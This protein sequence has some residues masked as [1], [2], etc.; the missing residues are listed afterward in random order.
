MKIRTCK[1]VRIRGVSATATAAMG[2]GFGWGDAMSRMFSAT[3]TSGTTKFTPSVPKP[4]GQYKDPTGGTDPGDQPS[5]DAV[6]EAAEEVELIDGWRG[7]I[8]EAM[9]VQ[10]TDGIER[11]KRLGTK[12]AVQWSDGEGISRDEV[13]ELGAELGREMTQYATNV[14]DAAATALQPPPED[15]TKGNN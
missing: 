8:I 6:S 12:F 10:L 13:A 15:A 2:C 7:A 11:G 3:P 1:Q 5:D 4:A 14:F 9:R